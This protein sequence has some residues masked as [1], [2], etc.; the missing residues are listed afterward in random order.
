MLSATFHILA[1]WN[2]L[3]GT[4]NHFCTTLFISSYQFQIEFYQC[5]FF[6]FAEYVDLSVPD[7]EHVTVREK[8]EYT[9]TICIYYLLQIP[10]SPLIHTHYITLHC[11]FSVNFTNFHK[12]WAQK[13]RASYQVSSDVKHVTVLTLLTTQLKPTQSKLGKIH[14]IWVYIFRAV[15]I[16]FLFLLYL[17]KA[18]YTQTVYKKNDFWTFMIYCVNCFLVQN[19]FY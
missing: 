12:L 10:N 3:S 19:V 17:L 2:N 7:T 6:G 16:P 13:I 4:L 18:F 5:W 9:T 14:I 1:E 11:H 15:I 8:L